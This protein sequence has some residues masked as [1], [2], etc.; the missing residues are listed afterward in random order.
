MRASAILFLA[1]IVGFESILSFRF[2]TRSGFSG[3][4]NLPA[5][6]LSQVRVTAHDDTADLATP[7]QSSQIR[8]T[9]LVTVGQSGVR[10][11]DEMLGRMYQRTINIRCPFFRRR[12]YDI[13]DSFNSVFKFLVARHK[14]LSFVPQSAELF[15]ATTEEKT[16]G[17]ALADI[18]AKIKQDWKQDSDSRGY[19]ITGRLS[20][21]IYSD[22]CFFDG[23]DP[24]MPVK[25]LRK[26]QASASQLFEY[27]SSRAELLA[28]KI[29]EDTRTITARW[30]IQ[31]RLNLPWHPQV[32]PWTGRTKY[33]VGD[34]GL[35]NFHIEEWDIAV[36]DA[37]V[38]TLFP[39][40]SR[41]GA[42]SALDTTPTSTP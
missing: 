35:V 4:C 32:K 26:Y 10:K 27:K 16:T 2:H 23:P 7:G 39:G 24:D 1:L 31:G 37:F 12:S 8:D 33:V 22:S 15:A 6:R 38:S 14:S 34:L 28:L 20:R 29:D 19:Y 9:A 36:V 11:L 17:L 42:P 3:Y 13:L 21:E 40:L 18:A 5:P 30:R 41:L 25:G